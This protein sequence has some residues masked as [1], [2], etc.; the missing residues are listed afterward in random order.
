MMLTIKSLAFHFR[1]KQIQ[2]R[3]L[4]IWHLLNDEKMML[5]KIYRDKN[6]INMLTKRDKLDKVK[7]CKSLVSLQR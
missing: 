2:I 5:E 1:T 7:L 3:Y 6:P 4:F